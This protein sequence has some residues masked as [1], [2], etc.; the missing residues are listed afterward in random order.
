MK[1]I[2]FH[3]HSPWH[4][5]PRPSKRLRWELQPRLS[6][7]YAVRQSV[8][9]RTLWQLFCPRQN[10]IQPLLELFFKID[11]Y[12]SW[13]IICAASGESAVWVWNWSLD[14]QWHWLT[15]RFPAGCLKMTVSIGSGRSLLPPFLP[16][17]LVASSGSLPASPDGILSHATLWQACPPALS[18]WCSQ[19]QNSCLG[20]LKQHTAGWSLGNPLKAVTIYF[21]AQEPSLLV[22]IGESV[23]L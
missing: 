1:K 13:C 20:C 18:C 21:E 14:L 4:P 22:R 5:W 19:I 7:L 3:E 17:V 11:L 16:Y 2:N 8:L 6:L 23:C 10:I 12:F 15:V 9:E